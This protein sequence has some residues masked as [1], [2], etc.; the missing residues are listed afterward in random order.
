[1]Y[2]NLHPNDLGYSKMANLWY[3]T[4]QSFLPICQLNPYP[5][6]ITSTPNT[7]ATVGHTYSYDVEATG[8]PTPVYSL[9]DKPAGMTINSNTGLINWIPSSSGSYDAIVN[10]SNSE[11]FDTQSFT[12]NVAEAPICPNEM[13][14]YWKL[15]DAGPPYVDSIG[16][17]DATCSNC[18]TTTTGIVGGAQD[19]DG[20]SNEVDIADDG[21]FDWGADDSFSIEY[22]MNTTTC[23]G[24]KVTVGRDD[25][26]LHW[27][28]GGHGD[29]H[30][31]GFQLR[32]STRAGIFIAGTTAV[33]DGLWHHIVCVR[34]GNSDTNRIYIDG[35]EENSDTYDYAHDFASTTELNI[36]YITCGGHYN[37][38]GKIDEV[39]LYNKALTPSEIQEHYTNGL[40]GL[41]YC[42]S[43]ITPGDAN[44]DGNVNV[45]DL[46]YIE[47]IILLIYDSTPGADVN[48]DGNVNVLDLT[49]TESIIL[50]L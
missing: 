13:T 50:G 9:D 5:P 25:G 14:H 32:D 12:I 48:G 45:L 37:F 30:S 26:S 42:E 35:T 34:N 33:D 38:D 2:D 7:D 31:A 10:A 17:N 16:G 40:N 23:A 19:F 18:P 24:N 15:D 49:A 3:S 29:S 11:G 39:A 20:S 4:L 44:G 27:W 22:W 47:N 43:M 28:T 21:T 8:F 36:G 1:M 41:G 6:S 46:T